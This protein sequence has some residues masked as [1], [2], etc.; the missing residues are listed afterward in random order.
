MVQEVN[1]D[2]AEFLEGAS[3]VEMS[4][5]IRPF[6]IPL[7]FNV[8]HP[9]LERVEVRR[10]LAEAINRDEIVARP[11]EATAESLT[12]RSG[13]STGRTTRRHENTR[14][15][16]TPRG[17]GWMRRA[18]RCARRRQA[19][20]RAGSRS[21]ACSGKIRSS[22]ASRCCCSGSSRMSASTWSSKRARQIR[23]PD[24]GRGSGEFDTY[25]FQMTSGKS[26]DW[27][28]RFWHSP[29]CG[30]RHFRIPGTAGSDAVLERLRIVPHRRRGPRRGRRFARA[31]LRG[32]ACRFSGLARDDTC[33]RC[34]IRH[35][36]SNPIPDVFANLWKW[37]L[38]RAPERDHDES[39]SPAASCC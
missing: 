37:R 21:T 22:S 13:L 39:G 25:L 23:A 12:I 29:E 16:R 26:F 1:R 6:Y 24:S 11:C 32:R 18:C 36:R 20:W 8:R 38:A 27:T 19:G 7:V 5:T 15:T 17:C 28:Y 2:S 34:A 14:T 4:S 33:G 10:A 30:R 35:R 31:V 9:I 3:Q